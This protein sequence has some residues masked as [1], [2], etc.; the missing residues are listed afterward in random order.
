MDYLI[1]LQYQIFLHL[2]DYVVKMTKHR[3]RFVMKK[4]HYEMMLAEDLDSRNHLCNH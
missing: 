3:M 1:V 2:K 4:I